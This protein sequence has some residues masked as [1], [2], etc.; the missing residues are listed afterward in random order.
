MRIYEVN[1]V[2]IYEVNCVLLSRKRKFEK[3]ALF[4][5]FRRYIRTILH[6]TKKEAEVRKNALQCG[7][8]RYIRTSRFSA[9]TKRFASIDDF[10]KFFGTMRLTEV[11][12][13]IDE[14]SKK[15]QVFVRF[16]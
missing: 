13:K 6:F 15:L 10:L 16:L 14:K 8:A 3:I 2:F 1:C 7:P 5:S 12:Q 11:K 9:E 4:L